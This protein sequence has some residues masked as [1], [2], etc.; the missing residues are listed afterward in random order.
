[1]RFLPVRMMLFFG[2]ALNSSCRSPEPAPVATLRHGMFEVEILAPE[3]ILKQGPNDIQLRVRKGSKCVSFEGE[4]LVFTMP[5]TGGKSYREETV[6]FAEPS[7]PGLRDGRVTFDMPGWWKGQLH[8]E[9][10]D[11]IITLTFEVDVVETF[12]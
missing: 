2:F 4:H 3:G 5:Y 12:L 7:V 1:M 6:D 11:D 9:V 8:V 10:P